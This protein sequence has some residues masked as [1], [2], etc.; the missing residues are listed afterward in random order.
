MPPKIKQ[1]QRT[2]LTE[3]PFVSV[4]A[5]PAVFV[6]PVSKALITAELKRD[7]A[8]VVAEPRRARRSVHP[9]GLWMPWC[10]IC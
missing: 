3:S 6:S 4:K 5:V 10:F 9:V 1:A 7:I 2:T 8:L